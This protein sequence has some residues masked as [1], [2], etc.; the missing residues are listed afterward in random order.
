MRTGGC[1]GYGGPAEAVVRQPEGVRLMLI[2]DC[3]RSTDYQTLVFYYLR[4]IGHK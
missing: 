4:I 1:S 2:W 3:L